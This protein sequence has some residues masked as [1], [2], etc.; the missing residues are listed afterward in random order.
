MRKAV[1]AVAGFAVVAV[2]IAGAMVL[3]DGV[4]AWPWPAQFV[5]YA[6]AGVAWVVPVRGIMVWGLTPRD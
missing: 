2:W 4:R 6:V 3:A 1:A 5:F